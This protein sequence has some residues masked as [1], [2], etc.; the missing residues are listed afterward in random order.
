MKTR[1]RLAIILILFCVVAGNSASLHLEGFG[2]T[3]GAQGWAAVNSLGLLDLVQITAR[4][5]TPQDPI[6]SVPRGVRPCAVR[7]ANAARRF[8]YKSRR[9]RNC[10]DNRPVEDAA[11]CST[12]KVCFRP[13][14]SDHHRAKRFDEGRVETDE[15]IGSKL[16]KSETA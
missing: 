11:R 13:K 12:A 14:V 6:S 10:T 7:D 15:R 3:E 2:S 9:R 1:W 5:L 4:G 16:T 8:E